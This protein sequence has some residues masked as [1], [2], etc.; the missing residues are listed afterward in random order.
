M[1]SEN[2]RTSILLHRN[3]KRH[4]ASRHLKYH[5][6]DSCKKYDR[7]EIYL[8]TNFTAQTSKTNTI[9]GPLSGGLFFAGYAV[10]FKTVRK[11]LASLNSQ[12]LLRMQLMRTDNPPQS[13]ASARIRWEFPSN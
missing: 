3:Q 9:I 7:A 4:K 11:R 1:V 5:R 12:R 2:R 10:S 13:T 6:L 8:L